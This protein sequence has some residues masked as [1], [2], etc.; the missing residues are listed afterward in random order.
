MK[1]KNNDNWNQYGRQQSEKHWISTNQQQFKKYIYQGHHACRI[2][3]SNGGWFNAILS[4]DP[5]SSK[6]FLFIKLIYDLV[7]LKPT[8][9]ENSH[10][11]TLKDGVYTKRISEKYEWKRKDKTVE[12]V[13]LI[14]AWWNK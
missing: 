1:F 12:V 5:E 8:H 7:Y 9:A 14:L 6:D 4:I 13:I 10:Q 2:A 11:N 3:I